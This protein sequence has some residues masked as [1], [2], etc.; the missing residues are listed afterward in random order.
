MKTVSIKGGDTIAKALGAAFVSGGEAKAIVSG[1]LICVAGHEK[2]ATAKL[3]LVSFAYAL[4]SSG[5]V[6]QANLRK[7][8]ELAAT[9]ENFEKLPDEK[10]SAV[11]EMVDSIKAEISAKLPPL[12]VAPSFRLENG[13]M[14]A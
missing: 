3:G 9:M 2:R 7:A 8:V 11:S 10:F 1:N 13:L 4:A 5:C 12:V 6:S 14:I